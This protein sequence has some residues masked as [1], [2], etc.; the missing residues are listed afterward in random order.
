MTSV[1]DLLRRVIAERKHQAERAPLSVPTTESTTAAEGDAPEVTSDEPT[2]QA[3]RRN[4]TDK[5]AERA[6]TEVRAAEVLENLEG[7]AGT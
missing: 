6:D 1:R 4:E 7:D 3:A 2:E 5:A